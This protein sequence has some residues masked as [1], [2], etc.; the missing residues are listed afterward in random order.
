MLG[1]ECLDWINQTQHSDTWP[2]VVYKV[3]NTG[4]TQNE[5]NFLDS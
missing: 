3:L 5:R 2:A 1:W 4:E